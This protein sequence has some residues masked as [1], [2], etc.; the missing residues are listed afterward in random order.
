M[1]HHHNCSFQCC[2]SVSVH[3][4]TKC[5]FDTKICILYHV[6]VGKIPENIKV[7]H[8]SYTGFFP[9]FW[10]LYLSVFCQ[11]GERWK[12][13]PFILSLLPSLSQNF[14]YPW[15]PFLFHS[16][17]YPLATVGSETASY[18]L[19]FKLLYKS[20]SLLASLFPY[21][22]L[23]FDF[24]SSLSTLFSLWFFQ[25][26]K[27]G[28]K[29]REREE[30]KETGLAMISIMKW[31]WRVKWERERERPW[32]SAPVRALI[33][34]SLKKNIFSLPLFKSHPHHFIFSTV[35]DRECIHEW[36]NEWI[37]YI[38]TGMTATRNCFLSGTITSSHLGSHTSLSLSLS[39]SIL[40]LTCR[41]QA[42]RGEK[43]PEGREGGGAGEGNK[44][45]KK[46]GR[47]EGKEERETI[48]LKRKNPGLCPWQ[49]R[50][51][52]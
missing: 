48:S 22:S 45:G 42:S 40:S 44:E 7:I 11:E 29:E 41:E 49:V 16:N 50:G 38:Q 12:V 35:A 20:S 13:L 18:N 25:N 26:E 21:L 39:L 43:D 15:S 14:L 17:R 9:G 1:P 27:E 32:P 33:F 36:V 5:V 47:S 31:W 46:K 30:R 23:S 52:I 34:L 19:L 10:K 6:L 2:A 8:S 37:E 3:R 28:T 24:L 4:I 51:Q